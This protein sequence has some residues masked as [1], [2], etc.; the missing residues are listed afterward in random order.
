VSFPLLLSLPFRCLLRNKIRT[1]LTMLG[2]VIGIASV[3]AMMAVGQGAQ[4]L[5]EARVRSLGSNIIMVMPGAQQS[6]G[7]TLSGGSRITLT[8]DDARAIQEEIPGVKAVSPVVQTRGQLVYGDLNWAPRSIR[9]EGE[10]YLEVK[11]WPLLEGDFFS[12]ED[13][14]SARRVCVIGTTVQENLFP[15]E[16]PVGKT[17]RIQNMPFLV[18]GVLDR[19]GTS[20]GG[21]DQDDVVIL[22]WTTVKRVLQGSRFNNLDVVLI[23]SQHEETIPEVEREVTALLQERHHIAPTEAADFRTLSM[24]EMIQTATESTKVMTTMLALIA[25]ISLLV[26]G[27]GIMNIMLVTVAE[28]TREIGL[29]MA[30][31]ARPRDILTQF[32]GEALLLALVAGGLGIALGAAVTLGIGRIFHWPVHL[33]ADAVL[34]SFVSSSAVGVF[35]GFYPS[36][37]ASRLD[38][39]AALRSE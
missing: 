4:R 38:P 14:G 11:D 20:A 15:D 26:G 33:S 2:I 21:E 8:P 34:L 39:I 12:T 16:S 31:G 9:G 23:S 1:G 37:R 6:G 30:V 24:D 13:V 35:F 36:L 25:S 7:V 18:L 28:R 10:D 22:P 3:I 32:L 27:V 5:V 19:K 17:M 29:R